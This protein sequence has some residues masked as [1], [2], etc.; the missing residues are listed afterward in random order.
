VHTQTVQLLQT[1]AVDFQPLEGRSDVPDVDEGDVSELHTPL[2]GD[3]D[4]EEQSVDVVAQ[5]LAAGEAS[6]GVGP[7]AVHGPDSL[8]LSEHIFPCDLQVVVDVVGIT[9]DKIEIS[10]DAVCGS[11]SK[12]LVWRS[13]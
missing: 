13:I 1:A 5:L 10:H 12:D 8:R 7:H 11:D 9:V 6:V 4:T 2:H 3:A